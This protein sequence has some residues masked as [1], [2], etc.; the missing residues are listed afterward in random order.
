LGEVVLNQVVCDLNGCIFMH[1]DTSERILTQCTVL[2]DDGVV[3]FSN[4]ENSVLFIFCASVVLNYGIA[5]DSFFSDC[6]NSTLMVV[7]AVIHYYVCSV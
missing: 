7:V 3:V 6:F 4:T 5:P 1:T 2:C